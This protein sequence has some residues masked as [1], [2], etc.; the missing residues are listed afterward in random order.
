MCFYWNTIC[1]RVVVDAI[2]RR[3]VVNIA[4]AFYRTPFAFVFGRDLI[5]ILGEIRSHSARS[6]DI[7]DKEFVITATWVT[8]IA[9]TFFNITADRKI[10]CVETDRGAIGFNNEMLKR[11]SALGVNTLELRPLAGRS[12]GHSNLGIFVVSGAVGI[13]LTFRR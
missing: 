3:P 2:E 8:W 7:A 1:P 5:P 10:I 6:S 9:A 12:S 4:R 13:I 11:G